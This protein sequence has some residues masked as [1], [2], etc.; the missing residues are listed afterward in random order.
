MWTGRA[1]NCPCYDCGAT[2]ASLSPFS[3]FTVIQSGQ[4]VSIFRRKKTAAAPDSPTVGEL[5]ATVAARYPRRVTPHTRHPTAKNIVI[6]DSYVRVGELIDEGS[7]LVFVSGNAG[8]G[9]TTLIEAP[10]V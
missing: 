9:K 3:N 1:D 10:R 2:R 8:T 4:R 7:P 6:P 5:N